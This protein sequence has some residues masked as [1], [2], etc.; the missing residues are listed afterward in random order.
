MNQHTKWVEFFHKGYSCTA[1]FYQNEWGGE[2]NFPIRRF[3]HA[4][5]GKN[6]AEAEKEFQAG[7]EYYL[8]QIKNIPCLAP[9]KQGVE[10]ALELLEMERRVTEYEIT[11]L[12]WPSNISQ[13]QKVEILELIRSTRRPISYNQAALDELSVWMSKN[14]KYKTSQIKDWADTVWRI[15]QLESTSQ[16]LAMTRTRHVAALNAECEVCHG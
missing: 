14:P 15:G 3:V 5:F 16:G 12:D 4:F 6:Q 13:E 7:V 8:S 1:I 11:L 9:E 2:F 10:G